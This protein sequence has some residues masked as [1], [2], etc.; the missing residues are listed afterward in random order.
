MP[1]EKRGRTPSIDRSASQ[2]RELR[3]QDAGPG[4]RAGAGPTRCPGGGNAQGSPR[5]IHPRRGVLHLRVHGKGVLSP[6]LD[7][8]TAVAR[9]FF[10]GAWVGGTPL[11]VLGRSPACAE[12][13]SGTR[14]Q[15][16]LWA[17]LYDFG[18]CATLGSAGRY[19]VSAFP[20]H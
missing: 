7:V 11:H 19:V 9:A 8:A 10:I 16:W 1:G 3:G 12:T 6:P 18:S 14:V 20:A 5:D 17:M 2:G 15:E 13:V 4:R